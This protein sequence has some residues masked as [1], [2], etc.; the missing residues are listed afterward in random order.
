MKYDYVCRKCGN[1]KS[2]DGGALCKPCRA[3]GFDELLKLAG[4]VSRAKKQKATTNVDR[5]ALAR[6]L[7]EVNNLKLSALPD[8]LYRL[9][10]DAPPATLDQVLEILSD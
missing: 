2:R 6:Q 3:A 5:V 10:D 8:G 9:G 7:A 1:S 4:E